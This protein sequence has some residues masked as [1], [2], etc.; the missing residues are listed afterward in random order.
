[1]KI[2]SV[3][4]MKVSDRDWNVNKVIGRDSINF[5]YGVT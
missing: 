1:M 2:W 4:M 3:L 5:Q